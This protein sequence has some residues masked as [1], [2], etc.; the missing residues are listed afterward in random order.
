[1]IQ[2]ENFEDTL[3]VIKV[4]DVDHL[5]VNGHGSGSGLSALV[6]EIKR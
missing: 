1:V 5:V 3:L 6:I 2:A 4:L